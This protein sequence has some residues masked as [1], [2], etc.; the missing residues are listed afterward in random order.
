MLIGVGLFV[1]FLP[2]YQ[3]IFVTSWL[4]ILLLGRLWS[5]RLMCFG[6]FFS[7]MALGPWF[8]LRFFICFSSESSA[9]MITNIII[10][11]VNWI[12]A[13][14]ISAIPGNTTTISK[15]WKLPLQLFCTLWQTP[16]QT[17]KNATGNC[18]SNFVNYSGV[19]RNG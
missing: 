17:L 19:S 13:K 16:L 15:L 6:Y 2:F 11:R 10:S 3:H 4:G 1:H 9:F 12:N 5:C 7:L 14:Q 18:I 8:T